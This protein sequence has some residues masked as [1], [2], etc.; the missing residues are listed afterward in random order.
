MQILKPILLFYPSI[1]LSDILVISDSLC[2]RTLKCL[3]SRAVA[4]AFK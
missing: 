4:L 3:N 1:L 2:Q